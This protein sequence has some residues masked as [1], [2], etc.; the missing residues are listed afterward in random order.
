MMAKVRCASM[1]CSRQSTAV[2]GLPPGLRRSVQD[3]HAKS[4]SLIEV[5]HMTKLMLSQL[6]ATIA[7]AQS[8]AGTT[9]GDRLPARRPEGQYVVIPIN[10]CL[11][12]IRRQMR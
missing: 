9:K 5:M 8:F 10:T 2:L 7:R 3:V 11:E 6:K 4:A 12:P 1:W